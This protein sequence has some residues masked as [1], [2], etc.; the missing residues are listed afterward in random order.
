[1]QAEVGIPVNQTLALF[2]KLVRKT[3]KHLQDLRKSTIAA[4]I[5]TATGVSGDA[6]NLSLAKAVEQTID[7]ELREAGDEVTEQ[8]REEQRK[9]LEGLDLSE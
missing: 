3:V 9:R 7:E 5:P 1:M 6:S 8:L 4:D 2:V